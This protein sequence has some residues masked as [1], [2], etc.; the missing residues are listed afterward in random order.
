MIEVLRDLTVLAIGGHS[1]LDPGLPPSVDNQFAV[2]ARA[3]KP[4]AELLRSG[5][6]V[7]M[8]HGNGPQVGFLQMRSEL[9]RDALH[10]VPLDSLVAD[11]QG[12]LGYMIQRALREELRVLG[13]DVEVV[14]LVTEVEVDALDEAFEEPTKPIGRFYDADTAKQ[15]SWEHGWTFVDDAGRGFRRV[16]AS[17]NPVRIVQF[18]TIRALVDSGVQVICCGGG[19]IPISRQEDGSAVGVECV[20][21]KDRVSARLAV[22][23]GVARFVVTTGVDAVYRGYQSDAPERIATMTVEQVRAMARAGEFPRGSMRPKMDAALYYLNRCIQGEF[24]LC[25]PDDL[26][27]ALAGTKGTRIYNEKREKV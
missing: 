23:L 20:I 15:M 8:T 2:T 21:D 4:V 3:M 22:E 26:I 24:I 1:L 6:K 12:S 13:D 5:Q 16:V 7:L 14:T 25:R 18:D 27:A 17:P 11:T 9:S 19:G 10:T